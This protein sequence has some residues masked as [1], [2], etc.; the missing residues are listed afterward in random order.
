M[1]MKSP[2][3]TEKV[4]AVSEQLLVPPEGVFTVQCIDV[5]VPFFKTVNTA[6]SAR[7]SKK[8]FRRRVGNYIGFVI[9]VAWSVGQISDRREIVRACYVPILV[10]CGPQHPLRPCWSSGPGIPQKSLQAG[11][12]RRAL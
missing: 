2:G 3:S 10:L 9:G 6:L 7:E 11:C 1:V 4:S 8:L 5:A 12:S